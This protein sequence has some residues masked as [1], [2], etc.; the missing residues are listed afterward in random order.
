MKHKLSVGDVLRS[1]E[2]GHPYKITKIVGDNF[3]F[4]VYRYADK[5][6]MPSIFDVWDWGEIENWTLLSPV[7][8]AFYED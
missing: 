4:D 1:D 7:E 2:S 5:K 6:W 8:V 3:S